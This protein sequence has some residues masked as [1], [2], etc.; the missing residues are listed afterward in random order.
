MEKD[1]LNSENWKK[2]GDNKPKAFR[3]KVHK[4][5]CVVRRS[6]RKFP[7]ALIYGAMNSKGK[8]NA[9]RSPREI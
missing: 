6:I 1:F 9:P 5:D 8:K 7:I 4:S 3:L 2:C